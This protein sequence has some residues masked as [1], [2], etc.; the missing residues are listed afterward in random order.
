MGPSHHAP[1]LCIF[2]FMEPGSPSNS[3]A[4]STY[5]AEH[6]VTSRF[7]ESLQNLAITIQTGLSQVEVEN[8]SWQPLDAKLSQAL[9][10]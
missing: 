9:M 6:E 10:H 1:Q 2:S 8:S 7:M 5:R 3:A 4:V